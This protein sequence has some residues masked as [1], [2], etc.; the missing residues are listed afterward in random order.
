MRKWRRRPKGGR[1]AH[2]VITALAPVTAERL[3][4][5]TES[6]PA[7]NVAEQTFVLMPA[8]AKQPAERWRPA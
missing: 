7:Q 6:E 4:V 2:V 1:A 5:A 8:L 3:A